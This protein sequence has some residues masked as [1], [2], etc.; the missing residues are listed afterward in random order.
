MR[1]AM[2]REVISIQRDRFIALDNTGYKLC[3]NLTLSSE[4]Y[5]I[6]SK[7]I[8]NVENLLPLFAIYACIY[9]LV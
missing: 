4:I 9:M 7:R 3:V 1:A 2:F 5:V 8:M 6:F